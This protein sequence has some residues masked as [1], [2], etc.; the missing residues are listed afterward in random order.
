MLGR[1]RQGKELGLRR[2]SARQGHGGAWQGTAWLGRVWRGKAGRGRE[3][4]FGLAQGTDW[5]CV[6][7]HCRAGHGVAGHGKAGS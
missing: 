6:A 3:L 7:R 2:S 1:A 5:R 4:G